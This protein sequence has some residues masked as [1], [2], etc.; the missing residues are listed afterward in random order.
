MQGSLGVLTLKYILF[1]IVDIVASQ[2]ELHCGRPSSKYPT[3]GTMVCGLWEKEG[4]DHKLGF[5]SSDVSFVWTEG[6][7]F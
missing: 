7:K 3:N 2:G 1:A 6:M 4:E 5:G